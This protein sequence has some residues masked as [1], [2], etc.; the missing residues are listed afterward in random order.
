MDEST[1][2]VAL[3][4]AIFPQRLPDRRKWR[5]GNCGVDLY[6]SAPDTV[7]V[8]ATGSAACPRPQGVGLHKEVEWTDKTK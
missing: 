2:E 4:E 7:F 3:G 1:L 8:S 5:C 6:Y